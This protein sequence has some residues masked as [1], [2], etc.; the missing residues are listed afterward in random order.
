M[1]SW[2]WG[3]VSMLV[4]AGPGEVRPGMK[5]LLE[6]QS[7]RE[8]FAPGPGACPTT[9]ATCLGLVVHMVF[10]RGQPVVDPAWL[11]GQVED[12]NALFSPIAVGFAVVDLQ[13]ESAQ[14][15]ELETRGDRDRVG[16][17]KLREGAIDVFVVR[18]L[19]DVDLVGE[20]IRGVHWRDRAN[21][22][23]RWVILSSLASSRVLAH[24]LGHFFG[25]PHSPNGRSI[26][27]KQTGGGRPPW[28]TRTFT[29]AELATMASGRDRMR[30]DG[31]LRSVEGGA[32]IP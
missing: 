15:A 13:F 6:L 18:K 22:A 29:A 19:A 32:A 21:T 16:R 8:A 14:W 25:L 10:E 3:A 17:G 9:V 28:Q 4:L 12:A 20:Q 23:Q 1:G 2:V 30:A 5:T 7:W 31:T 27:N 26:M 24:E 11:A